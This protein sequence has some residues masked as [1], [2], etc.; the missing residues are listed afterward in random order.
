MSSTWPIL[1]H[2][3]NNSVSPVMTPRLPTM[4][5]G[6]GFEPTYA[7]RADL[8]SAAFNHSATPPD[9]HF[10]RCNALAKTRRPCELKRHSSFVNKEVTLCPQKPAKNISRRKTGHKTGAPPQRGETRPHHQ[11]I[12]QRPI[13]QRPT[14]KQTIDPQS[15]NRP[16]T[17][18][19]RQSHPK[20]DI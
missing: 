5:V 12:G 2:I 16:L 1:I 7:T 4:V 17:G 8:Q 13:G 10:C 18:L 6:V 3:L 15:T 11:S 20:M 14:G 19:P 9:R